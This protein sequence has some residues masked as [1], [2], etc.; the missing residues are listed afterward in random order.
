MTYPFGRVGARIK[1]RV[2]E[3]YTQGRRGWV[4]LHEK[5]PVTVGQED[6]QGAG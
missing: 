1:M 3:Y 4:R 2:G 5:G 6:R